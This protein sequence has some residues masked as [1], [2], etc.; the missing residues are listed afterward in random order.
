[1]KKIDPFWVI[2]FSMLAFRLILMMSVGL[3]DD[4]TYHWTWAKN[5]SYSYF[6]HPGMVAWVIWPFINI[7]GDHRFVVRWPGFLIY[8]AVLAIVYHL[9]KNLFDVHAARWSTI[10]LFFIPLWGFASLG[11][12]PDMV[13]GIFWI[14]LVYLFWQ[15]VR[16]DENRW[17][18][19]KSWLWIG[20]VMGIGMN[21]KLAC[22]LLGLGFGLYHLVSLIPVESRKHSLNT[23]KSPWPYL[24]TVITFIMMTPILLWNSENEWATFK[25]QFARRHTEDFGANWTRWFQFIGYQSLLMSPIIYLL[26]VLT[27]IIAWTKLKKENWRLMAT[28]PLPSLLIFYYQALFSAYKPH[29]SGPSYMILLPGAVFIYL[30]GL[31]S[32]KLK[33]RSRVLG[34]F[35]AFFL[36][37][38][39]MLYLPLF[40]PVVPKV[41]AATSS[42]PKSWQPTW[43]FSNEFFGWVEVGDYV[44][45]KKS[46]LE[47]ETGR[48]VFLAAQRYE[49]ISQ[50]TWGVT[51]S[52][53][54]SKKLWSHKP[55]VWDL[56]TETSQYLF[57][58]P[59]L[60]RLTNKGSDFLIVN[61]DKYPRD[62]RELAKFD[63]CTKQEFPIYRQEILARTF[64]I[65]T[66]RNFAG[67]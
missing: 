12:L 42:Q 43:D 26:M 50:L 5:L 18:I 35:V 54:D 37:P 49:L 39:N 45:K 46:Q 23:L 3:I 44:L 10:L 34:L 17:S 24:G 58:Q 38:L 15:S 9:A 67:F 31:K 40:Y 63:S 36:V 22:C 52:S 47:R 55:P 60:Q 53:P 59:I 19:K 28:L 32:L 48:P 64:F 41:F 1:M 51:Q 57:D 8:S 11:T 30:N 33:S 25:Y 4:E 21:A 16:P 7:F 27:L 13:L 56:S 61:N 62:P 65:Y 2:I 66:C 29:W 6:D 14:A 20:M